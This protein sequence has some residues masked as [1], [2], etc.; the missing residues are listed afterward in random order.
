[1]PRLV[2]TSHLQRHVDCPECTVDG[3]TVREALAHVFAANEPLRSYIVDDLSHL[4]KHVVIF[5][6]GEMIRDRHGLSDPVTETS[7]IYIMQALSG[8]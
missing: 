7:E 6:D 4:R 2:F 8:G 3:S 5:A 1:M